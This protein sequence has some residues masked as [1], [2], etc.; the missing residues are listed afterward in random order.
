MAT[1]RVA[2][3]GANIKEKFKKA[4]SVIKSLP[5][6]GELSLRGNVYGTHIVTEAL[7]FRRSVS[8]VQ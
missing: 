1:V 5:Q 2:E 7:S 8:A 4:V 6:K 3:T